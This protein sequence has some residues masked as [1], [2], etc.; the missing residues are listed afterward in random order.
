MNCYECIYKRSV[1]GN[2]HIQC[3]NPDH[4]MTGNPH[5]IEHDWF[6]YPILF[7]PIWATK[8]CSNFS[9]GKVKELT[10]TE[11]VK[12]MT[13]FAEWIGRK[14][15]TYYGSE[16]NASWFDKDSHSLDCSTDKLFTTFLEEIK[17][18]K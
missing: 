10:V 1:P 7:D 17:N 4:E 5:G 15:Y 3:I 6:F 12:I 11:V 18:K 16:S 2:T 9:D 8:E 13:E 14:E